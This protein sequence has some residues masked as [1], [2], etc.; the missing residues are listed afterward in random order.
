M[1]NPGVGLP[2]AI[3]PLVLNPLIPNLTTRFAQDAMDAKK[4]FIFLQNSYN[5]IYFQ[6]DP[7][8]PT[9]GERYGIYRKSGHG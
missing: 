9:Q 2:V 3:R 4:I 1:T 6:I 8:L 7:M 5:V